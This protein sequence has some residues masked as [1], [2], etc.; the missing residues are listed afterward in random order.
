MSE[1]LLPQGFAERKSG[2]IVPEDHAREREVWTREES[3]LIQRALALMARRKLKA[4]VV[5]AEPE[6]ANQPPLQVNAGPDGVTWRCGHKDREL[7]RGT[8]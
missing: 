5:C 2:L 3:T 8:Q 1:G 4:V 7:R 6:C